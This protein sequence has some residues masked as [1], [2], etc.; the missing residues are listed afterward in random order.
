MRWL[1]NHLQAEKVLRRPTARI[2]ALSV[3]PIVPTPVRFPTHY[4]S[5]ISR[6]QVEIATS[7]TTA[8]LH[9]S[10]SSLSLSSIRAHTP[11]LAVQT[12]VPLSFLTEMPEPEPIS[13]SS[14][15][16]GLTQKG[17]KCKNKT[18]KDSSYCWRHQAQE[19]S[20]VVLSSAKPSNR[21]PHS[22]VATAPIGVSRP[23]IQHHYHTT[24]SVP[25]VA[26]TPEGGR[27]WKVGATF[28]GL[29]TLSPDV[30]S[31]TFSRPPATPPL[32][33][34]VKNKKKS[35]QKGHIYCYTLTNY[36]DVTAQDQLVIH[37]QNVPGTEYKKVK[38]SKSPFILI[39]IGRTSKP[40]KTRLRQWEAHCK[41]ELTC[42]T[43]YNHRQLLR[44]HGIKGTMNNLLT[45]ME[46]VALDDD[47]ISKM[48]PMFQDDGFYCQSHLDDIEKEIHRQLRERYGQSKV[49]CK[50]CYEENIRARGGTV[51]TEALVDAVKE[52]NVHV[53]W[54]LVP[55][56]EVGKVFRII[57]NVVKQSAS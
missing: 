46:R 35:Q 55:K 43:P 44:Q 17:N 22:T 52:A 4:D 13:G 21:P 25:G 6:S 57:H 30:S 11:E 40:V 33:P 49:F 37:I 54:F 34:S 26:Q 31:H 7:T 10:T 5:P 9:L 2:R 38:I 23:P 42:L 14:Q 3:V 1:A 48:F 51:S 29:A 18:T 12:T 19:S 56:I 36:I 16:L 53:E 39:K 28:S 24:S 41:H 15:C 47:V 45:A 50:G 27:W 20:T 32:S 8:S